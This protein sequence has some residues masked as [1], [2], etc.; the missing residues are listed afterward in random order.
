[1]EQLPG[2][3]Q[4]AA[5]EFAAGPSCIQLRTGGIKALLQ[6][7]RA[8]LGQGCASGDFVSF[9]DMQRNH[10]AFGLTADDAAM[11]GFHGTWQ[12]YCRSQRVL[13]GDGIADGNR[14]ILTLRDDRRRA[15][16][17]NDQGQNEP[18]RGI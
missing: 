14:D 11:T 17:C 12:S 13:P 7:V 6:Y 4:T 3:L 16:Q 8:K 2:A 18:R 5:G 1:M 10:D 9:P 15:R